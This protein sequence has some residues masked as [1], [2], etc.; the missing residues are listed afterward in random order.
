MTL[1]LNIKHHQKF[2]N[3]LSNYT[4]HPLIIF[5]FLLYDIKSYWLV[6]WIVGGC[7]WD[8]FYHNIPKD[9]DVVLWCNFYYIKH[10]FNKIL[11]YIKAHKNCILIKYHVALKSISFLYNRY[12]IDVTFLRR[13]FIKHSKWRIITTM[14]ATLIDDMIWRDFS[15][16]AIYFN[17]FIKWLYGYMCH[18][19]WKKMYIL[20]LNIYI[21]QSL[22]PWY[23][24]Y[25]YIYKFNINLNN[26]INLNFL[27]YIQNTKYRFNRW[28]FLE[29]IWTFYFYNLNCFVQVFYLTLRTWF[30]KDVYD[31]WNYCK[32]MYPSYNFEIIYTICICKMIP[33][34]MMIWS[35][36]K[37]DYIKF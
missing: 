14:N 24:R 20:N 11:K 34:N 5:N 18:L 26:W 32:T 8:I 6:L 29:F 23:Y 35:W 22:L 15:F 16:N 33:N 19:I 12:K 28:T 7:I 13:T 37:H 10:Y 30:N 4:T 1:L 21:D 9:I 3:I 36:L 27:Y 17:P 25:I 31:E 2:I